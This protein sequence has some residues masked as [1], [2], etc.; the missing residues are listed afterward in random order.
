RRGIQLQSVEHSD[1]AARCF[2]KWRVV[3]K[4]R[5]P[6]QIGALRLCQCP[7]VLRRDRR[8]TEQFGFEIMIGEELIDTP[9]AETAQ[10]GGEQVRVDIDE[11]RCGEYVLNNGVHRMNC[12]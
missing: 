4:Q 3:D 7:V 6:Y 1:T 9:E 12:N 11:A 2:R 8:K 5:L 10:R